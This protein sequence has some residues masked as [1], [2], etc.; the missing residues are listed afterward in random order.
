[1]KRTTRGQRAQGPARV[2]ALVKE[3]ERRHPRV[4]AFP[5]S[6]SI[7]TQE[8]L[9]GTS[10]FVLW[11]VFSCVVGPPKCVLKVAQRI[12]T[13]KNP[14]TTTDLKHQMLLQLGSLCDHN[15]L[16][17]SHHWYRALFLCCRDSPFSIGEL[18]LRWKYVLGTLG[19]HALMKKTRLTAAGVARC[20]LCYDSFFPLEFCT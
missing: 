18:Q 12:A 1:M 17:G 20:S 5:L 14:F 16:M 6:V 3:R 4:I 2:S 15:S 10:R 11:L 13:S 7:A 8:P 19:T 9:E